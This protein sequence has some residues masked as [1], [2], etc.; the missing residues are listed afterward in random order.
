MHFGNFLKEIIA[1][2]RFFGVR[3]L[4]PADPQWS[5]SHKMFHP[6][7]KILATPLISG[8]IFFRQRKFELFEIL[9]FLLLVVWCHYCRLQQTISGARVGEQGG[10]FRLRYWKMN[11]KDNKFIDWCRKMYL[12]SPHEI[13]IIKFLAAPIQTALGRCR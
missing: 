1:N 3:R 9:L 2:F 10:T 6:R 11:R 13:R 7:N 8:A 5:R 4:C 12:H